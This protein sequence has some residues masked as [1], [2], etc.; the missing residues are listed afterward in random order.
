MSSGRARL[1]RHQ[2]KREQATVLAD[3]VRSRPGNSPGPL[4]GRR[5][6]EDHTERLRGIPVQAKGVGGTQRGTRPD[7]WI[8]RLEDEPE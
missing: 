6:G 8:D 1:R 5:A 7:G 3:A 2:L 4:I